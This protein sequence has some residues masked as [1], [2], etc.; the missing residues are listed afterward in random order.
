MHFLLRSTRRPRHGLTSGLFAVVFLL[1]ACKDVVVLVPPE[2]SPPPTV[3][4]RV[5]I[6]RDTATLLVTDSITIAA[7]VVDSRNEPTSAASVAWTSSDPSVLQH[8]GNGRFVARAPGLALAVASSQGLSA[9]ARIQVKEVDQ[10][11]KLIVADS[12]YAVLSDSA[13]IANGTLRM[14][15]I[16]ATSRPPVAGDVVFGSAD[17]GFLQKVVTVQTTGNEVVLQT[18]PANL[19][20]VIL[21]GSVSV[22]ED[23]DIGAALAEARLRTG[24]ASIVLPDGVSI[25][26]QGN[27]HFENA[28]LIFESSGSAQGVSATFR[29]TGDVAI[30]TGREIKPGSKSYTFEVE[31]N[32]CFPIGCLDRIDFGTVVGVVMDAEIEAIIGVTAGGRRGIPIKVPLQSKPIFKIPL[33]GKCLAGKSFCFGLFAVL[34]AYAEVEAAAQ[35]SVRRRVNLTTGVDAGFTWRDGGNFVP[36]FRPITSATQFAP[37]YSIGGEAGLRFGMEAKLLFSILKRAELSGGVDVA[38]QS[39]VTAASDYT[40]DAYV[41][42][43]LDAFTRAEVDL[44]GLAATYEPARVRIWDYTIDSTGGNLARL[45]LTPTALSLEE[46]E[47]FSVVPRARA[48]LGDFE[49]P[50]TAQGV[51]W[52]VSP[53][54]VATISASGVVTA[55]EAGTATITATIKNSQISA[56]IPLTVTSRGLEIEACFETRQAG[57]IGGRCPDT[58]RVPQFA[59]N[60]QMTDLWVRAKK[61]DGSSETGVSVT[62]RNPFT[63]AVVNPIA[64]I[65]SF[66]LFR[67]VVPAG[68]PVGVRNVVVGPATKPGFRGAPAITVP[69]EV[70]TGFLSTGACLSRNSTL[71]FNA[72]LHC[73]PNV[74]PASAGQ[75]YYL[76]FGA[77]FG[78]TAR[79]GA[80]VQVSNPFTGGLSLNLVPLDAPNCLARLIIPVPAGTAP[81]S[82]TVRVGP[83]LLNGFGNSQSDAVFTV[84]IQ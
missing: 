41:K 14:R 81:G 45:T 53:G 48:I 20:E 10:S 21:E 5:T 29:V 74:P 57:P 76:W 27:V 44:L 7:T 43:V 13:E 28:N 18:V 51:N 8:I 34:E 55:R 37:Q 49:L 33:K 6:A 84:V 60:T 62:A 75:S 3:A 26:A 80:T 77:D 67:F 63:D 32:Y 61:P 25:D 83:A 12:T 22:S 71:P 72:N 23:L 58:Q 82:Y 69:I 35:I 46:N 47:T 54:N 68:T 64:T 36:Y 15:A 66:Q 56:S 79:C 38:L 1:S 30:K 24:D 78:G 2:P 19:N 59:L 65:G 17:G 40:W 31:Y 11:D 73:P 9:T 52:S 4:A 50:I 70:V 42:V 16:S 39:T